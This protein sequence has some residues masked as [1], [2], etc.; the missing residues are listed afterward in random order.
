MRS[1][2][3][4][5]VEVNNHELV[6]L[7]NTRS[8]FYEI[9]PSD[10]ECLDEYE[11]EN[12]FD[13][14]AISLKNLNKDNFYKFY[15]LNGRSYLNT[16]EEFAPHIA[17]VELVERV[18]PLEVFFGDIDLYSDFR[19]YDDYLCFNGNYVRLLSIKKFSSGS[20]SP[21]FLDNNIDFFINVK[22]KDDLKSISHLDR[23]RTSHQSS[24]LKS[25]RDIK[26]E[27]AYSEAEGLIED[28]TNGIE[29]LVDHEFFVIL[30]EFSLEGLN[31]KTNE[32]V[33]SMNLKGTSLFI[34]GNNLKKAK[35]GL[36]SIF[37]ELI[38]GVKPKLNLRTHT[39]K[40][41]HLIKLLP[42]KGSYLHDKGIPLK[43]I[44]GDIIY[45]DPFSKNIPSRNMLVSG[46]TGAGK[47]VFVNKIIHHLCENHPTVIVDKGGSYKKACLY[48]EGTVLDIGF[49]PMQFNDPIYLREIILSV[50]DSSQFS[51]LDRGKL[52]AEIKSLIEYGVDDFW[53][54]I[55]KLESSFKGLGYYFEDIKD[56]I[57]DKKI[58]DSPILYC[59]LDEYP[60]NI[61]SPFIIFILE[62]FKRIQNIEKILVFDECWAFLKNHRDY[63]DNC[64]RTFRKTGAFPVSLA[65]SLYDFKSDDEGLASTLINTS[66]FRVLFPQEL[67]IHADISHTDKDRVEG[68]SFVKNKYT[69]CYLKSSDNK[70]RKT[71]TVELTPLEW[72]LFNT[73]PNHNDQFYS[74]FADH[75]KYFSSN[76]KTIDSY[77]RMKYA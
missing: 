57:T 15:Y 51:K 74:Y 73:E 52:L 13:E 75:R 28:I 17:G 9:L 25:K 64:Y 20:V 67:G 54:L 36:M 21:Y 68:L 5:I 1:N 41:S 76:K 14:I 16:N 71:L 22:L 35:S 69:Q 23:I 27:N 66:Y 7:D 49:N 38:P 33:S 63:I 30:K 47:S 42:V 32:L 58:E 65:Q 18:N 77:I 19:V 24:F 70:I 8:Y 55:V 60:S 59:D 72:E 43:D 53:G 62:Y 37:S 2:L 34:E 50:V 4:P 10:I 3:F 56:Y 48:H 26:S 61:V 45:L 46:T 29:S 44:H 39:D 12:Y 31:K 40:L 11:L 6:A